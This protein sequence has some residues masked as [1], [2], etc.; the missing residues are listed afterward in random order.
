MLD[1]CFVGWFLQVTPLFVSVLDS[2]PVDVISCRFFVLFAVAQTRIS[3]STTLMVAC[4][5][6]S[7]C[8]K[9]IKLV[10]QVAEQEK[11]AWRLNNER[12]ARPTPICCHEQH[13]DPLNSGTL[14]F[15][16]QMRKC[17]L[18][19]FPL[20]SHYKTPV[21]AHALIGHI[22]FLSKP[23]SLVITEVSRI[24]S[25]YKRQNNV[26]VP[27]SQHILFFTCSLLV[28]CHEIN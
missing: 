14:R 13:C 8:D 10:G 26:R 5:S 21:I 11:R 15:L 2:S 22:F 19:H 3:K 12:Y 6:L 24:T 9:N 23:I 20:W 28:L 27:Q 4:Q 25:V 18:Q 7:R 17:L 1:C 16:S